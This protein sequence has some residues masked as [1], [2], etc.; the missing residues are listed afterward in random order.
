M[1]ANVNVTYGEIQDA[2]GK[3]QA[4]QNELEQTLDRLQNN[5]VIPLTTSGFVTD[6]AS[7]AFTSSYEQFTTG[8]RQT[9]SGL[10]GMRSFLQKTQEAMTQLDSQLASAIQG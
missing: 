5:V 7:G 8:A 2:I 10:E 4:G 1:A 3:L 9:V 6:K